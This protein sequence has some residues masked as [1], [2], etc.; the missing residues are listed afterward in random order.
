[1]DV[2]DFNGT[3]QTV[4]LFAMTQKMLFSTVFE[5]TWAVVQMKIQYL[6]KT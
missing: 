5:L 1:M 4:A 6:V 2:T 3:I